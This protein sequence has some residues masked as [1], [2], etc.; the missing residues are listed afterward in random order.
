MRHPILSTVLAG[1][2]LGLV[3]AGRGGRQMPR[4]RGR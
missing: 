4:Q 1:A 3:L 2:A